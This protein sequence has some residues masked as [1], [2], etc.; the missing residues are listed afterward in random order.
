M[1]AVG[2]PLKRNSFPLLLSLLLVQPNVLADPAAQAPSAQTFAAVQTAL[3]TLDA[4]ILDDDWSFT[5]EVEEEDELRLIRSD[6]GREKYEKRQLISVNGVAPDKKRQDEF[7]ETEVERI[8]GQDPDTLGYSYMVDMQTLQLLE[9]G[10]AY[11]TL[12]FVPRVK[13]LEDS[14]EKISGILRL[15]LGSGQIDQIEILNTEQ[16]SPAFSV[17]VDTYRLLLQFEPQQ[18]ENLLSKLE[19]HA[20]GKAGFVKRFES[21][22]AI[23]FSDFKRAVP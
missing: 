19:S 18:G 15:N 10:E 5:M 7:R 11:A 3:K 22:V 20:A 2:L 14:R 13:A 9:A 12:S 21:L 8:D 16:L 17:T 6:P 1:S 4:T 23:D